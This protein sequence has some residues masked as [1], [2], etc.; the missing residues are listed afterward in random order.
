MSEHE[1]EQHLPEKATPARPRRWDPGELFAE[2]QEEMSRLWSGAPLP[3]LGAWRPL[4]RL[5]RSPAAWAPRADIY[6][7]GDSIVVKAELPGVAKDD[8]DVALENGDLIIRG[9]RKAEREVKEEHYYRMER[10]SG[11]FYRRLPLPEGT[12]ADQI[13]ARY[14][15]GVLE[16]RVPK[17][18][19]AAA[20]PTKIAVQ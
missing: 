7:Q 16:V 20:Q 5:A 6:E 9:E 1:S 8:I 10:S 4:Q 2:M 13:E 19:A 15:D 17:P 14:E 18:A 12:N 3:P 11:S